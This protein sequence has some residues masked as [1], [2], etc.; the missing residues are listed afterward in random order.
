LATATI[1]P[2]ASATAFSAETALSLRTSVCQE[3]HLSS[4]L[5]WPVVGHR[6]GR[7]Q[8]RWRQQH[9]TNRRSA[10]AADAALNARPAGVSLEQVSGRL[11]PGASAGVGEEWAVRFRVADAGRRMHTVATASS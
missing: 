9:H 4:A 11:R 2:F 10:T 1:S 6:A 8:R 7:L 3:L 5:A